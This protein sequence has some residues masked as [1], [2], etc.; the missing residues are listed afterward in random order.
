MASP[1]PA[2]DRIPLF[3]K[4]V[5]AAG[6]NADYLATI[7][8]TNYIWMPFFNIGLGISP[9]LL[10]GVLV[11]LRTWDAITD[12][13]MGNLSDNARTR[14]GR[15]RPFIFAGAIATA[16]LYPIFWYMP[17]G[18]SSPSQ[19]TYLIV[20]GIIYFAALTLWSMP[21]YGLQ[22][23]L[24]PNY[25]E[26]TRLT[27]WMTL[28]GKVI[29]LAGGWFLAVVI[30]AGTL[31]LDGITTPAGERGLMDQL[32]ATLQPLVAFLGHA[33]PGEKPIVVGMRAVC[34]LIAGGI[35][36]FGAL[37]AIFV[38]ERYYAAE[39]SKQPRETFWQSVRESFRC[40]PLWALIGVSFFLVLGVTSMSGLWQYVNIYYVNGGDIAKAAVIAGWKSTVIMCGIA[41]IP[42]F[43]WLGERY[44]KRT[45]LILM[46]L[47]SLT[48]HLLNLVLM[49]PKHPYL[50]IIPGFFESSAIAA[51][52]LFLPSM[53]ADVA[54][55]DEQRTARRREGSLN[56][57]YSWFIKASL[58]CS[59][60]LGGFVLEL[61][62]FDAAAAT[63]PDAVRERM[64]HLY[65]FLPVCI[66]AV[67]VVIA[68][69]YPITRAQSA[70][71]R[72]ALEQR[73]GRV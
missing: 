23:E 8:T 41:L 3:Q 33:A 27:A 48:G 52:W 63:Q 28:F 67:A 39:A 59:L 57:F 36:I 54:D 13:I 50:Q 4:L 15:R 25:D 40:P 37:P 71:T 70:A 64:F 22:L 19:A 62:G 65:L 20:V 18:L 42:V 9:L 7:L 68:W 66:W 6:T 12:P 38:K 44:D 32:L 46:L 55:W 10:G 5:F 43:T 51:I 47:I 60:G 30:A 16:A 2:Q 31:A 73:R 61:S 35:L 69:F 24:T 1:I 11:V 14:W 72:A 21:Y 56:A 26:R 53:K 49:T 34:W 17:A 58:T 45:V 29:G